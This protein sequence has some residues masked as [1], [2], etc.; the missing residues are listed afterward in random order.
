MQTDDLEWLLAIARGGSFSAAAKARG[1]A[2]STAARHLDAL[3]A[4]LGLRLVDRRRDGVRLTADGARIAALAEPAI[5]SADQIERAAAT[6]RAG[7]GERAVVVSATE[8]VI[9]EILAPTLPRLWAR[10]PKVS[11]TLRSQFDLVSLAGRDADLAIRMSRPEGASL[12]AKKLPSLRLGLFASAA[13]LAG[14]KPAGLRLSEE[15]LLVYDDSHRRLPEL[16]WIDAGGF[17]GAVALRTE[18]T[19]ALVAAADA[20]GGIALLPAVLARPRG[21]IEV[22]APTVLRGRTPWLIVH[23]DL[24]RLPPLR[25]VHAWIMETFAA[26][27]LSV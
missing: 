15:R 21:L 2:V 7:S 23:R 27:P 4:G 11:V 1:V 13:Y 14:R 18:S 24:R 25:V 12:I 10:H 3:E 17:A 26:L 19:R 22:P 8:A 20:G 6:L 16:D 5:D 9:S